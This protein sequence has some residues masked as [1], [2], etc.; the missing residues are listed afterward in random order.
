MSDPR[1]QFD[2]A[3]RAIFDSHNPDSH[4]LFV[5]I[6]RLLI[7]YRLSGTYE[8]YDILTEAYNRGVKLI[9]TGQ[10]IRVPLGWLR[11]TSLNIIK[12][13]RRRQD[14]L[15]N[16]RLDLPH[17]NS[18]DGLSDLIF[19]E[20]LIAVKL[21]FEK[22]DRESQFLLHQRIVQGQSWRDVGKAMVTTGGPELTEGALRQRGFKA[23][24]RLRQ[25]YDEMR[26]E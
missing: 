2:V 22:L 16:P 3:V 8:V 24:H 18:S 15:D 7:Q 11:R 21:A 13:F 26:P 1:K 14:Q 6:K 10:T 5:F 12:E 25:L 4:S 17:C 20:D 23:L 19:E 9:A